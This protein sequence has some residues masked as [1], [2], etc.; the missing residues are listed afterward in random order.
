MTAVSDFA[1]AQARLQARYSWRADETVW[2][3]LHNIDD[4]A[5]YLQIAQQTALRPWVLGIGPGHDSH[6][7]ELALRQKYRQHVEEVASWMPAGWKIPLQW[8]RRLADLPVL[9]YLLAGGIALEWMRSDPD[10]SKFTADDTALRLQAMSVAGCASLVNAWQQG[11]TL[12]SGWLSHWKKIQPHKSKFSNGLQNMENLLHQ[13]MQQL[14]TSHL[15]A[16]Q[17]DVVLPTDYDLLTD[18]MRI[19]FRRYAF[20]PA[21]VCAYLA[22]IAVDIHRIRS[23]LMQR[24]LF[25]SNENFDNENLARGLPV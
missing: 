7:I 6:A 13:H 2:L 8:I 20:Q 19:I 12:F 25:Q 18:S 15:Q 14:Q 9:Q 4:L 21:A 17:A 22:L 11:D 5:S 10:I 3:R 24:L 16:R 23:D 1:Y